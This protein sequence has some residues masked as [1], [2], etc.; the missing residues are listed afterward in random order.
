MSSVTSK[1]HLHIE[2]LTVPLGKFRLRD[3]SLSCDKGE[4]HILLGPTGS[5]KSSL[6]KSILGLHALQRG[7]IRL[8]DRDITGDPP[9]RRRMG[10]VPQD[11]ALFPHLNV[12]ENILFATK[13]RNKAPRDAESR[14]TELCRILRIEPLRARRVHGLS[15]GERQRVALAR[16]LA[17]QPEIILLDEPFSS[18]DEG[19][20]RVLWLELKRIIGEVGVTALHVTHNLEEAYTLGEKL[21]VL[22]NGDLVQTGPK[23]EIFEQPRS[24]EV[25]RCLNYRNIF[26]GVAEPHSNGTSVQLGHFRVLVDKKIPS[27]ERVKLCIRQQ[28]IKIVREGPSIKDSL[29]R[30]VFSGEIVSLLPLPESCLMWFKIEGSPRPYDFELRFP[31]YIRVRHDLSPGQK[32]RVALWE[33]NIVLF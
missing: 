28:D 1:R 29:R 22:I 6:I 32:V 11:Y 26:S 21:S 3:I 31:A 18:I 23:E 5:G 19:V 14:V 25:A 17:A 4:Y 16:A 2:S 8:N 24:E 7:R 15:G 20:K 13:G 10:Y 27:G 12:E 30:N 9:E 33:P